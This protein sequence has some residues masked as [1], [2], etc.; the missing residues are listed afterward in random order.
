MATNVETTSGD[1]PVETMVYT[2]HVKQYFANKGYGFIEARGGEKGSKANDIFFHRLQM[3]DSNGQSIKRG[4]SVK[5]T[6]HTGEEGKLKVHTFSILSDGT[7]PCKWPS[8][9]QPTEGKQLGTVKWFSYTKGW[10]FITPKNGG[11]EVFVH[12]TNIIKNGFRSLR[13]GEDVEFKLIFDENKGR[14]I[15]GM[16]SGPQGCDTQGSTRD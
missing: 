5:F 14:T 2:G 11:S 16:V 12:Q 6:L 10:G 4:S 1:L 15:A 8:G 7:N 3:Q 9:V 13:D